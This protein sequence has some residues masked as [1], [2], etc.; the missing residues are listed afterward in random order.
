MRYRKA[1]DPALAARVQIFV[2]GPVTATRFDGRTPAELLA[3]N[4]WAWHDLGTAV[5]VPEGAL[6]VWNFD[7]RSSRWGVAS[8]FGVAARSAASSAAW[9][10]S[11]SRISRAL[12]WICS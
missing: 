6:T 5:P 12:R 10:F 8:G 11:A 9:R 7:G 2:K 1:R 3:T 4:E